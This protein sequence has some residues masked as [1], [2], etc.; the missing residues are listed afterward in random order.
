MPA[1][2]GAAIM[3][4][5]GGASA[6]KSTGGFSRAIARLGS[7]TASVRACGMALPPNTCRGLLFAGDRR[8]GQPSA[9]FARSCSAIVAAGAR[10]TADDSVP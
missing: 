7:V 2:S 1:P 10:M 6:P 5:V 3:N 9:E 8:G 4:E